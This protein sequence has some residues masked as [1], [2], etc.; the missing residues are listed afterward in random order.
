MARRMHL[1]IE[2]RVQGVCYRMEAC[3][4]ARKLGLTGWIRNLGDGRVEITAEGDETDLATMLQWC[5]TG[6][7]FANVT[8]VQA[9]YGDV[10]GEFEE[11][12]VEHG[13]SWR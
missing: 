12:T 7:M 2:G 8:D 4:E 13:N 9:D 6:P 10:S 3:A 11:F 1:L 5:G